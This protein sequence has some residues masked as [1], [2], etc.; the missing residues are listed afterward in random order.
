MGTRV[1]AF[2]HV[3]HFHPKADMNIFSTASAV[4]NARG[5]TES[6]AGSPD[7][8]ISDDGASNFSLHTVDGFVLVP[9]QYQNAG[10]LIDLDGTVRDVSDRNSVLSGAVKLSDVTQ[11]VV[12]ETNLAEGYQIVAPDIE[13]YVDNVFQE[14]KQLL[15][16]RHL[17]VVGHPA[18]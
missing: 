1:C 5:N 12:H 10:E 4:Y 2:N 17:R 6:D 14:H 8:G 18:H 15:N 7:L 3:P 11:A 9:S 13:D 16:V